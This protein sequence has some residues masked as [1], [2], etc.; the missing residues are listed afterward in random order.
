MQHIH[1][2]L[3]N[4][5]TEGDIK[6]L[7]ALQVLGHPRDSK[8]ISM[9][10]DAGFNVSVAAFE[11]D[12][13]SGR[14]PGVEITKLGK[15]ENRNYLKRIWK[16][17]KAIPKLRREIRKNDIVYASGQD[18]AAMSWIAGI[19]CH[20][21]IVLEVGDIVN[22]QLSN[23]Y[24]GKV[25]RQIEKFFVSKY[26]LLVVISPGFLDGYYY[27]WLNLKVPGLILENKLEPD[28]TP[29]P[30][31]KNDYVPFQ[32]GP[33]RIG[34]FGLLRD[35]W[36]F[37]VLKALSERF[38]GEYEI[39]FAG[40]IVDPV[41]LPD[42]VSE[43]TNMKYLGEYRSPADLPVLY[44]QVDMIWACYPSIGNDD[45]NFKWGRPN[46]F[47]ESCFYGRPCFAR[48]GA[49]FAGDV[50]NFNIGKVLHNFKLHEVIDE[51][52]TID[53]ETYQQWRLNLEDLPSEVYLYG[54]ENQQLASAIA[55]IYHAI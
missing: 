11:R 8:R 33:M 52:R 25:V 31:P 20:R 47:F 53:Q 37:N 40:M 13:H 44:N 38:P 29:L 32:D 5:E 10:L 28:T 23:N 3:S 7:S 35:E 43:S 36:S 9:L 26:K 41:N 48:F 34:Y 2:K 22:I 54:H 46:R 51:I 4:G 15:I 39:V 30:L 1:R 45:W 19:G 6:I 17:L 21:P 49:H 12:Y 24:I 50:T 16:I 55:N 18:M 27:G 42:Q 14:L